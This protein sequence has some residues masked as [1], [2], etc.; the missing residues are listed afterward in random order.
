MILE[1]AHC[2]TRFE[3]NLSQYKHWK[4]ECRPA[5]CSEFCR[6]VSQE[7]KLQEWNVKNGRT[8]RKGKLIGPCPT[9]GKMFESRIDKIFCSLK[10][11]TKSPQFLEMAKAVSP[12]GSQA[13]QEIWKKKMT[14]TC[15]VCKREYRA[16]K[17]KRKFCSHLCHRK[18]KADLYDAW[19]ANPEKIA[20]PQ[21]YDEFMTKDEL[22]C[23]IEGCSW[24]GSHLSIHLNQSHGI[25]ADE[26]KRAAGFNLNT[27]LVC[28]NLNQELSQREKHI[29]HLDDYPLPSTKGMKLTYRSLEGEEA[30]AKSRAIPILGPNRICKGCGKKFT[31]STRFGKSLY[32]NV[33]CRTLHAEYR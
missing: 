18:F 6:R 26:F 14:R 12:K 17:S 23:L 19:I 13:V 32:C 5:Y 9:C 10:C 15:P 1:C 7:N 25:R 11:Y 30:R 20:L 29:D 22:P 21:C 27:G 8:L 28:P 24:T 31:Q 16:N 4:Y 33:K 3:G 2:K